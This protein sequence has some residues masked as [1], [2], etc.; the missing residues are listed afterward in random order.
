M[1]VPNLRVLNLNYN[2]LEDIQ[3]LEGLTR[4]R[5]LSIIGS[6]V[7]G[8]RALIRVVQ[9]MPEAEMF[10]FRQVWR[11]CGDS[12]RLTGVQNESMHT[13]VV[14]STVSERFGRCIVSMRGTGAVARI[15]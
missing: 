11:L 14:S 8:T 7:Q 13:W 10:D 9:R 2:F 6:R 1:L 15:G 5:K 3:A 4:L 12:C